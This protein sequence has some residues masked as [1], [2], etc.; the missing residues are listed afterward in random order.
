MALEPIP[1][2]LIGVGG[3]LILLGLAWQ[4]GWVQNLKLGRLP[5]DIFI[6]R[7]NLKIYIPLTTSLLVSL[8]FGLVS[9]L[10]KRF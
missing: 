10:L 1:K 8:I 7:E 4:W 5:G 6:E 9:W 3:F 2:V